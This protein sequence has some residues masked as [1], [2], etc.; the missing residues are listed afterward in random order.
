MNFS[1]LAGGRSIFVDRSA[2]CPTISP[3]P[4]LRL[5]VATNGHSSSSE[6]GE[7][8]GP[9]S[10]ECFFVTS[11]PNQHLIPNVSPTITIFSLSFPCVQH[12]YAITRGSAYG[13][14][15]GLSVCPSV[16]FSLLNKITRRKADEGELGASGV[17]RPAPLFGKSR[18]F[19]PQCSSA[20]FSKALNFNS[21]FF[22]FRFLFS[23]SSF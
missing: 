3:I 19:V 11:L 20:I 23:S 4:P 5:K 15:S 2:R 12:I 16:L 1:P 13:E 10:A 6:K 21:P 17:R 14:T 7:S 8:L 18:I 9:H 22:S